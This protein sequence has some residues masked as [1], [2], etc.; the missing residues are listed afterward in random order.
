M[1]SKNELLM[2]GRGAAVAEII[3]E[4]AN[5]YRICRLRA[6]EASGCDAF[7]SRDKAQSEFARRD[8]NISSASLKDYET[9]KTIPNPETVK[10]MAEVYGTP[11]LKWMHC[12]KCPIGRVIMKT[13][14]NIGE[15]DLKDTYFE[16]AGSFHKV[17]EIERQLRAIMEDGRITEEELPLMR[18]I[19]R[20]MDR[21]TENSKDLKIWMEREGYKISED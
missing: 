8:K 11:E 21:I 5:I 7:K 20:V 17:T 18:G 1:W 6:N 9:G 3:D 19:I 15:D 14:D 12:A 13:D 10:D 2:A 16:L 4:E